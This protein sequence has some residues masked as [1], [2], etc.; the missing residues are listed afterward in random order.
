MLVSPSAPDS[1]ADRSHLC[2]AF[3]AVLPRVDLHARISFRDVRCWQR[4]DDAIAETVALSSGP[5]ALVPPPNAAVCITNTNE[6]G[7]SNRVWAFL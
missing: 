6:T 2:F 3:L 5:R 4:R 7:D 1:I